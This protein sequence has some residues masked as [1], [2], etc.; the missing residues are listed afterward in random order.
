MV[1]YFD[2]EDA[3]KNFNRQ[4]NRRSN[5]S[6][7]NHPIIKTI[8]EYPLKFDNV[9]EI[10]AGNG[11]TLTKIQSLTGAKC[12]GIEPGDEA[13]KYAKNNFKNIEII[14]GNSDDLLKFFKPN[15]FDLIIFGSVLFHINPEKILKTFGYADELLKENGSIIIWDLYSKQPKKTIYK[16]GKD[17][18]CWKFN[19]QNILDSMPHFFKVFFKAIWYEGD[20]YVEKDSFDL[21]TAHYVSIH[22]K[23]RS[24]AFPLG[25]DPSIK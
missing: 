23:I 5:P 7:E 4:L 2:T 19:Q 14:Q 3:N 11:C 24:M 17:V 20:S 18:Y 22:R 25:E 21:R 9:L 13:I 8:I 12:T 10:G 6:S 15:S 1:K 16:H